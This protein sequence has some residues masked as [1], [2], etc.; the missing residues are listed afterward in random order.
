MRVIRPFDP[1]KSPLCTCPE[2]YSF[3]PY[4]GCA[5]GCIY[6]YATY[7]PNF[8][9]LREK[10]GLFRNLEKDLKDLP[11]NALISMSNSSDPYPPAERYREITRRCI[12]ILKEYDVRLMVVTKSDIVLRDLKIL[13]EMRSAVSIT[14]TGLDELEP[15]APSTERRI[16]ALKAVKDSGIPAILRLDP[17]IPGI[18]DRRFEIIEKTTPD[19]VVT[20]TLKLK[21]DSMARM[22]KRLLW[23]KNVSFEEKGVYRYFPEKMRREVLYRIK[24]FCENIGISVGFCREGFEPPSRSCDGSHL[25]G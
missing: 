5:H 6:C 19:H 3:N 2:K 10:K 7:I 25:L 23:L 15:N 1:W 18:N 17:V 11:A 20:S 13:S 24:N 16:E 22:G 9:R 4:T 8:Y 14:I 12:E 21:A